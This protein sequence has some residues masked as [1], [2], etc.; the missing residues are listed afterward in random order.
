MLYAYVRQV[1][2]AI[3]AA[4]TPD[5]RPGLMSFAPSGLGLEAAELRSTGKAVELRS[6]G[7]PGAAVPT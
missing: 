3:F 5:L 4:A 1:S 7:Q 2:L 6:T